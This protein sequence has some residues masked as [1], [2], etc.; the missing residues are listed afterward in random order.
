M[1]LDFS[2]QAHYLFALLPEIVLSVWGMV[3]LI[4][5][6]WRGDE[7]STTTAD[8]HVLGWLSVGG[9]V[10]AAL[11]NG[12]L[13]GVAEVGSSSMIAVDRFRLFANWI[14][15]LAAAFSILIS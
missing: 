12:W 1:E 13:Y 14:F 2:S 7:G 9:I 10:L 11:A 5:G 4:A 3:L 6:V 8:S 15:L